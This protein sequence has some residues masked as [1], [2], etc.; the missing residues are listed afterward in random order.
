MSRLRPLAK[1]LI[2]NMHNSFNLILRAFIEW[3]SRGPQVI[4]RT[5]VVFIQ[6]PS[7]G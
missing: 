1:A 5:L 7:S 3:F 4:L 2:T 6:D